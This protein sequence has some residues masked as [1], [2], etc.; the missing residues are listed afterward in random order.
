MTE[1]L[2]G[3]VHARVQG[4]VGLL[5]TYKEVLSYPVLEG[6]EQPRYTLDGGA[7]VARSTLVQRRGGHET[8]KDVHIT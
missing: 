7:G 2:W 1:M 5:W 4:M 3:E 8:G 6:K